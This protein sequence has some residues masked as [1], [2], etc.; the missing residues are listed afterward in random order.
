MKHEFWSIHADVISK[1]T[2]IIL[3]YNTTTYRCFTKYVVGA[4]AIRKGSFIL[5]EEQ[6]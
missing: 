5:A 6:K 2:S 1:I 3:L 4:F